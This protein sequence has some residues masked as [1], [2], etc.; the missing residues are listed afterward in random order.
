M[1]TTLTKLLQTTSLIGTLLASAP[2]SRAALS[3]WQGR[4]TSD[5]T[6]PAATVFSTTS[7]A[8]PIQ[9]DVGALDG[10][11]SF[12]FIVNAG[13]GG[14]SSAFLGTLGANGNQGLKFEQWQDA[15]V[16]GMTVFGVA[17][18]NSTTPSPAN[19]DTHVVFVSD[20]TSG[21]SLYVNGAPVHTFAG[22]PLQLTGMQGLGAI[23]NVNTAGFID[24]LDGNILGFASYNSALSPGEIADH[25]NYFAVVPEPSTVALF[26]L[27]G[28][29][30]LSRLL[31]CRSR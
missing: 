16:L 15:G 14:P 23:Y 22:T 12:E 21:T 17:D 13:L 6:A 11:R 26:G 24:V 20:G 29:L 7:G 31:K 5:G 4:V 9:T 30:V 8:S 2:L 27:A 3:D 18:F 28:L 10:D 19:V 1:K 25:Y